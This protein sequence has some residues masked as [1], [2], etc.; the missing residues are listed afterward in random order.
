M[1]FLSNRWKKYLFYPSVILLVLIVLIDLAGLNYETDKYFPF[2]YQLILMFVAFFIIFLT[3]IDFSRIKKELKK[4]ELQGANKKIITIKL[5]YATG[6]LIGLAIF[7]FIFNLFRT[8]IIDALLSGD[9]RQTNANFLLIFL[10]IVILGISGVVI[11]FTFLFGGLPLEKRD[12][13]KIIIATTILILGILIA[14]LG[15][16]L[17]YS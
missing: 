10:G 17:F 9:F 14:I 15:M 6:I 13:K 3:Y 11:K 2:E 1:N 7:A 5:R 8:G 12:E 4:R 16:N